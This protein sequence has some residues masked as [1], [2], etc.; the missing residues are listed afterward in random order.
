MRDVAII[1]HAPLLTQAQKS[2]QIAL[3]PVREYVYLPATP[4]GNAP[5]RRQ[6]PAS[7]PEEWQTALQ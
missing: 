3:A 7:Q 4:G 1:G 5:K 2:V 6:K